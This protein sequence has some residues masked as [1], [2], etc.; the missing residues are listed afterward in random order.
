MVGRLGEV[1]V[2]RSLDD[3]G[4]RCREPVGQL[5]E[6]LEVHCRE[7]VG[8]LGEGLEVHCR[9]PV[10]QL[11]EDL[12]VHCK[13]PVGHFGDSLEVHCTEP[14]GRSWECLGSQ[15]RYRGPMLGLVRWREP[16][17]GHWE[18]VLV[19]CSWEAAMGHSM[20]VMEAAGRHRR[21]PGWRRE[22]SWW[23]S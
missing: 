6:G 5:E 23:S 16:A 20:A 12:E 10:G 1:P 4:V 8:Q 18:L 3:L 13:E 2:G 7:P 9:E 21:W 19:Q 11:G 17:V 14:V 22:R 15:G